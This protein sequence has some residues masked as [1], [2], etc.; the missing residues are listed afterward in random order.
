[1]QLGDRVNSLSSALMGILMK[2]TNYRAMLCLDL[3][4]N[5]SDG[6]L[7]KGIKCNTGDDRSI[8]GFGKSNNIRTTKST[9]CTAINNGASGAL[10][11]LMEG[12]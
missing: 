12:I 4:C 9:T 6:Y 2:T 10:D 11:M 5:S 1:M 3:P 8:E 7:L